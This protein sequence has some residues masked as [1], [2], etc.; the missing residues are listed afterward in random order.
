MSDDRTEQWQ[1]E[2]Q[3][4]AFLRCLELVQ[5]AERGEKFKTEDIADLIYFLGVN[6]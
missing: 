1:Q 3:E 4:K 2:D 6:R 5:M